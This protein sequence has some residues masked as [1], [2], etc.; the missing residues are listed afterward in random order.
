MPR[1]LALLALAAALAGCSRYTTRGQGPFNRPLPSPSAGANQPGPQPGKQP[2][3]MN[4]TAPGANAPGSPASD[5]LRLVPPKPPEMPPGFAVTPPQAPRPPAVGDPPGVVPAGGAAPDGSPEP[6]RPSPAAVNLAQLKKLAQVAG[7]KWKSVDTY[8][9]RLVRRET[10]NGVEGPREEVLYQFRKEPMSIYMR[11]T[12]EAGKDRQVLYVKGKYGDKMHVST[13][14]GDNA[15]V[16]VGFKITISPD[17]PRALEK[18]RFSIRDAGFGRGINNFTQTVEKIESG[19]LPPDTL[20]YLGPTQRQEYPYPLEAVAQTIRPGDEKHTPHGGT[21]LL[22]FDPKPE[23]PSYGLPV[24]V[25]AT[26]PKGKELEYYCFDRFRLPAGLT[27]ADFD[28]ARL[29]KKR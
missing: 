27:D 7:N 4:G 28:P 19:R 6:A 22:Y 18:S 14:A 20:K 29:T 15:F 12:S 3:A 26:D 16:G 21:R 8:E 24:L 2:L 5:E 10:V 13:G 1:L 11:T 17:D 23:S 9:A 25:V